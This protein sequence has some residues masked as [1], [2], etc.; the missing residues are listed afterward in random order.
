MYGPP[1]GQPTDADREAMEKTSILSLIASPNYYGYTA[2]ITPMVVAWTKQPA[3]RISVTGS[4][5][6]STSETAFVVPLAIGPIGP[7]QLPAGL[8]V[9]RFTDIEGTTQTQPGGVMMQNGTA[10]YSF[11]PTLAPGKHLTAA[12][13]DST[14]Q[15]AKGGPPAA[16]GSSG[17]SPTLQ[18][19]VWDWAN[20]AWVS[21]A[22]NANG[23]STLPSIAVDPASS[24]VR[25]RLTA[26]GGQ[27][28]LGSISL[29]G[30]VA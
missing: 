7:G 2:A 30:T 3:E 1:P 29:V 16:P 15:G 18:A 24:E 6:R 19:E 25:L 22:Y 10:T 13:L 14:N 28:L 4:Q 12:G 23:T 20:S 21:M 11:K 8:V 26:A 17:S 5:T 27:T 9:S